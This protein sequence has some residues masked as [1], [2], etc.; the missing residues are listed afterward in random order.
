MTKDPAGSIESF[1]A[2]LLRRVAQAV[3]A[4]EVPAD[5]LTDLQA[6]IEAARGMPQEA[7]H[8]RAVRDIA[9]RL[10]IPVDQVEQGLSA[11]EGHPRVTRE[12]LLREIAEAWLEGQRR[13]WGLMR[14]PSNAL[15][16]DKNGT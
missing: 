6:Q 14:K 16:D 10:R 5:L 13:T 7:G 9:E 4:G 1:Q 15:H 8:A 11:L 2:W 3:E 12:L